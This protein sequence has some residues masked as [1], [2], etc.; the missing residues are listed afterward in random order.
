MPAEGLLGAVLGVN[1]INVPIVVEPVVVTFAGKS[2]VIVPE[3]VIGLPVTANE[4]L[5]TETAVT[6]LIGVVEIV[7]LP[8][9][10]LTAIP[11]PALI[12]VTPV[13]VTVNPGLTLGVPEV[14]TCMPVLGATLTEVTVPETMLFDIVV[15]L[16]YVSTVTVG[17]VYV[18]AIIPVVGKFNVILPALTIGEL[19]TDNVEDNTPTLVTPDPLPFPPVFVIVTAPLLLLIVIPVPAIMLVTPVLVIVT[20]PVFASAE[21]VIPAPLAN[22]L[23]GLASPNNVVKL[24]FVLLKAVYNES[25]F[26]DSFCKPIF[27]TC[28]PEIAIFNPYSVFIRI[29]LKVKTG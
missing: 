19:L 12:L 6:A 27:I 9:A 3:L 15:T 10:P 29:G 24:S 11:D 5:V 7:T 26:A 20:V 16:P 23:Y 25:L 21:V 2:T 1:L 4:V 13:F 28:K 18:P 22:T 8:F 14:V 17:L